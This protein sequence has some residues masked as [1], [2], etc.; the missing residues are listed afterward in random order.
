MLSGQWADTRRRLAE[1]TSAASLFSESLGFCL[2]KDFCYRCG[3]MLGDHS[4]YPPIA[5]KIKLHTLVPP[6]LA[7]QQYHNTTVL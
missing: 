3:V 6:Q 4:T 1:S 2:S 5:Q 7:L